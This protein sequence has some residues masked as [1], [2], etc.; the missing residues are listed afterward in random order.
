MSISV[1]QSCMPSLIGSL[2]NLHHIL[3]KAEEFA[4]SKKL[5]EATLPNYR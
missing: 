3:G 1:Y 5:A 2:Q 4:A